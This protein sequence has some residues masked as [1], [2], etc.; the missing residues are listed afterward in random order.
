MF[1]QAMKRGIQESALCAERVALTLRFSRG[2]FHMQFH[3]LYV[4][5][6]EGM[7]VPRCTR[8]LVSRPVEEQVFLSY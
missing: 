3:T 7:A 4:L 1:L 6:S 2:P 8:W 5:F